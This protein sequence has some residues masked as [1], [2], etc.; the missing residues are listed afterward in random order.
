MGVL[1]LDGAER[2][3][4]VK[5]LVFEAQGVMEEEASGNSDGAVA[6][7]CEGFS[8]A[9]E[10]VRTIRELSERGETARFHTFRG[11]AERLVARQ[12]ATVGHEATLLQRI[13]EGDSL[14][15]DAPVG[16]QERKATKREVERLTRE[17]ATAERIWEAVCLADPRSA[18]AAVPA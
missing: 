5:H 14:G 13:D 2:D 9:E 11:L 12:R 16:K 6:A 17:C 10:I 18:A 8:V 7:F 3:L 4:L 1:R 15:C